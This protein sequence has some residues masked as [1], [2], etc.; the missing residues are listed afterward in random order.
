MANQ[1]W[2][3]L[4]GVP[5]S[6]WS[7]ELLANKQTIG[8]SNRCEI[9]LVHDTVS[10]EHAEV[11]ID[12]DNQY[13]IQD[14]TSSNGTCVNQQ[15]VEAATFTTGDSLRLGDVFLDVTGK[16]TIE[17]PTGFREAKPT[18]LS[19]P[20]DSNHADLDLEGL[21]EAQLRVLRTLLTG[22]SEKV[23]AEELYISPHTVHSHVKQIYKHFGV[24]SRAE[25]MASFIDRAAKSD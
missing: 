18:K 2:L 22:K 21:S 17:E 24:S 8:R 9:H 12:D 15:R 25:L 11:W 3:T 5:A 1:A 23:V 7:Y 16:A 14:L 19:T 13:Q 10:R 20:A 6:L 4:R